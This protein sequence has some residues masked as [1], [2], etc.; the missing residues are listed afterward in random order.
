[1]LFSFESYADPFSFSDVAVTAAFEAM[2]RGIERERFLLKNLPDV[3]FENFPDVG[4]VYMN[5]TLTVRAM[6]EEGAALDVWYP[7]KSLGVCRDRTIRM[8]AVPFV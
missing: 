2:N 7:L 3:S 8:P 1:M 6:Q 5:P 4:P